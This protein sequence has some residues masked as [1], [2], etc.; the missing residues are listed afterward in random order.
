MLS[1]S[2]AIG[3]EE[4][5]KALGRP[6]WQQLYAPS[7][8][9][10][11]TQLLRRVEASGVSVIALTVDNTTG[12]FSETYLR[13]RPR[14]MKQCEQC[15]EGG[16]DVGRHRPMLDGIDMKG[17]RF[18]D[19]AM[20]WAFVDRLRGFWKG[21]LFI[22]GIDTREDA[23]LALDHGLDGILVSNHGG[24]STETG[25]S[26]IEALPEVVAEVGGRIPV[27]LDGGVRR[28][29]DVF[30]ALALGASGV[31]I[32]RP[33]L[34]GLGAFG[35]AGV[36]RVLEILQAELKLVMGNCGTQKVADITRA[37]VATPTWT[38]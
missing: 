6:V 37:Y 13:T 24:R 12:R 2:T 23:R 28:G 34:W 33:M 36:D 7:S 4:V 21:K 17:V 16:P 10:A 35:Q 30:K 14:D 25:R 38:I 20:D 18:T 22:K 5:N 11:C 19:P 1:T 3:V 9:D 8:W 29:T 15:H 26:T 27:F 31:G 32:G